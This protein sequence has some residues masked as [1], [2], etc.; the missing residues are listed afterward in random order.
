MGRGHPTLPADC[1]VCQRLTKRLTK[2]LTAYVHLSRRPRSE[3]PHSAPA[4]AA[5]ALNLLV[6]APERAEN[7]A[8]CVSLAC[9]LLQQLPSGDAHPVLLNLWRLARS[10]K[11]WHTV[12]YPSHTRD[13]PQLAHRTAAVECAAEALQLG[14]AMM[15][16]PHAKVTVTILPTVPVDGSPT[17]AHPDTGSCDVDCLPS[18]H[19]SHHAAAAGAHGRGGGGGPAGP[20]R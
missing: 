4:V 2:R 9:Q 10:T 15:D 7:R 1:Q 11:V 16:D 13:T 8:A 12:I 14:Q 5:L 19:Q 3:V 17:R 18:T 6:R 20:L